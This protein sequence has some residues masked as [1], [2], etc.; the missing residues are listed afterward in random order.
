MKVL[1]DLD[2]LKSILDAEGKKIVGKVCKR[3][4]ILID[5]EEIKKETK[6]LLYEHNRD[7][8]DLIMN[9]CKSE[10]AIHLINSEESPKK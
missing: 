5:K 9:I 8:Y 6:E 3:F 4:E 1:F 2:L 10:N 7:I